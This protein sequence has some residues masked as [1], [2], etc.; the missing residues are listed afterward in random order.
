MHL[1][2]T[3]AE[4]TATFAKK[5]RQQKSSRRLYV[6]ERR[7]VPKE[8]ASV[9]MSASANLKFILI[10]KKIELRHAIPLNFGLICYKLIIDITLLHGT[11]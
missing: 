7:F 3:V 8:Q 6:G 1:A 2:P 9:K 11:F 5:S 4:E 10:L